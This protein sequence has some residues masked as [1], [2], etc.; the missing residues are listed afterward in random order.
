[1]GQVL[2]L[3]IKRIW[4]GEKIPSRWLNAAVCLLYKNKGSRSDPNNYRGISL[5]SAA[6]KI[7]SIIIH[8][9]IAT[10]AEKQLSEKQSGFRKGRSCRNAVFKLLRKLESAWKNQQS[11]VV[12][13]V[14]FSKAF[15]SIDWTTMWKV[16][17]WQGCPTM[18]IDI[19][20]RMYSDAS[21][22]IRID[23]AG[24]R[25]AEKF[26]QKVGIRQGCSLSPLLFVLVGS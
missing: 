24:Q 9:R 21:L 10:R 18:I 26:D 2:W 14:D 16:L 13:F 1:M 15:D 25:F 6:E 20:K 22:S 17:A 3:M 23:P 7:L 12:N 4:K 5:L 19:M 8:K 11:L